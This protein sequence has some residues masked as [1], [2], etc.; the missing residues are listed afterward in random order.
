MKYKFNFGT[1]HL[2]KSKNSKRCSM[3]IIFSSEIKKE[4]INKR[5]FLANILNEGNKL[6][7]TKRELSIKQEENFLQLY[8]VTNTRSG[9]VNSISISSSFIS[10][11]YID[12]KEYLKNVFN[13]VFDGLKKPDFDTNYNLVKNNILKEFETNY[14]NPS[15]I[16]TTKTFELMDKTS[17]STLKPDKNISKVTVKDLEKEYK[18]MLKSEC[19]IFIIGDFNKKEILKYFKNL[20]LGSN[21][22]TFERKYIDNIEKEKPTIKKE[23]SIFL[24]T[25]IGM[26]YNL[27]DLSDFEK[28]HTLQIF[29]YILS[30]SGLTSRLYQEVREK[31]SM[32]YGIRSRHFVLDN[33]LYISVSLDKQN[34]LEAVK[35]IQDVINS[36]S[37]ITDEEFID[38]INFIRQDLER[39]SEVDQVILISH[40]AN[41]AFNIP[42]RKEKIKKLKKI[43]KRDVENIASK[44]KLNTVF[45][46][47]GENN[48][49]N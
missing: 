20:K 24:Q 3:E 12:E 49:K 35:V 2:I 5:Y 45:S 40:I 19:H 13:F 30:T 47:V 27:K 7:E 41:V 42:L 39:S 26:I 29:N 31:R 38:A 32:C 11:K 25:H 14:E 36:M 10:P 16:T 46:L 22:K 48:E 1:L 34:E 8:H 43:T 18:E 33:L 15:Y 23:K 9:N 6:Y 17:F 28:H 4:N 37:N 21:A 44:L